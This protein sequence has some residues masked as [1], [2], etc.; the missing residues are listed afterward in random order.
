MFEQMR[1]N[2]KPI[3]W[4]IAIVFIVGMGMMGITG[5]L[6]PQPFLAKIEGEKISYDQYTKMLQ[7]TYSQYVEQNPDTEIDERIRKQINDDTFNKMRDEILMQQQIKKYKIK[8]TDDDVLERIKNPGDD[9]KQIPE[10]QTDGEFDFVKYNDAIRSNEQF[11]Q[12]LEQNYR[13]S[14]PY[15]KLYERIKSEVVVTMEEVK[16]DFRKKNDKAK[17]KIIFF[18]HKKAG[19]VEVTE[20]EKTSYYEEHK[21]DYKRDPSC[22]YKYVQIPLEPSEADNNRV[23]S[24][25]DELYGQVTTENFGEMATEYSEG[26]SAEDEGSLDWFGRGKMVKEFDEMVFKMEVGTISKPIKTQFG[27]HIIYKRDERKTEDGQDEVLASHILLKVEASQETKDNLDFIVSDFVELVEKVGMDSAASSMKYSAKETREFFK[28][29]TFIS[30]IGREPSY[31]TFAFENE[32]GAIPEPLEK[33]DGSY[34]VAQLSS[35]LG[36]HYQPFSEVES[37]IQRTI[38]QEKKTAIVTAQADSFVTAYNPEEYLA[39]AEEEGWEIVEAEDIILEKSLPKVRKVDALNEAILSHEAEEWA[40]LI[41]DDKG[42]YLA[43]VTER[44][45]PD[46]AKFEEDKESLMETFRETKENE[47]LNEWYKNLTENAEIID[48]RNIYYPDLYQ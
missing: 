47:H 45:K 19:D 43:Y 32:V 11:V 33:T 23:K 17:A 5:I 18:D 16:E 28:D 35:K 15:E 39:K 20:A 42:A 41:K 21:E 30:G 1:R 2:A 40:E 31:I 34:I 46:M 27:W 13:R 38:E 6:N 7:N 26:P 36:E 9:I 25:I 14:I 4:V 48:N 10:F 3:F 22:K 44:S 29:G 37:R 24:R 8:V 12:I